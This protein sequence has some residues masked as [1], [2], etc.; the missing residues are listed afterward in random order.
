MYST[1]NHPRALLS[2]SILVAS[3]LL[4]NCHSP[5][6][7]PGECDGGGTCA[8][9]GL[10]SSSNACDDGGPGCPE[11]STP[12]DCSDR[13]GMPYC[14]SMLC[15]A[16][17]LDTHCAAVVGAPYCATVGA[18]Q[19]LQCTSCTGQPAGFCAARNPSTSVCGDDGTCVPC[20]AHEECGDGPGSGT[21]SGVCHRPGDHP[22]PAAAGTLVPGQCVPE[23]IVRDVTPSTIAAELSGTGVYLRLADGDY[24]NLSVGRD[25]V[26]VGRRDLDH[27]NPT[28]TNARVQ[29]VTVTA[30]RVTLSDLRIERSGTDPGSASVACTG[31]EVQLRLVRLLNRALGYGVDASA[32]SA[33][34]GVRIAESVIESDWQALELLAP[35]LSYSVTN[36]MILRSGSP[37]GPPYHANAVE[38]GLTATGTFAFNTLY[39]NQ[40]GIA[41]NS[42]QTVTNTVVTATGGTAIVGCTEQSVY[43]SIGVDAGANYVETSTDSGVFHPSAMMQANLAGQASTVV[44]P[45]VVTDLF[46]GTR[47][48]PTGTTPDIGCEELP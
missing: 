23:A 15:S 22:A 29:S 12:S 6:S 30:G 28:A 16:C 10:D 40:S 21:G 43:T 32:A 44:A 1:T 24:G 42:N 17:E 4:S 13:V 20:S 3:V 34:E 18:S 25:V 41:C 7:S 39:Q 33:C 47:P 45:A 36:T 2:A 9:V 14:V 37:G 19:R 5:D 48:R 8:D 26:L 35:N 27:A 31:G 11:C 38:F 46:G